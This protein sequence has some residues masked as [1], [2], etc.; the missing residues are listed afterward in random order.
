M[1]FRRRKRRGT[2]EK[3]IADMCF[4]YLRKVYGRNVPIGELTSCIVT[5]KNL[6]GGEISPREAMDE[7]SRMVGVGYS[8]RMIRRIVEG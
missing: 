7:L 5:L 1:S 2:S 8:L 3:E 4:R 6:R